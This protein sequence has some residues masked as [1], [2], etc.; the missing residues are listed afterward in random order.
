M[1]K[2]YGG[3]W[4]ITG[5]PALGRGG[6]SEVF[7]VTDESGAL[8]GEYALKR[9][10]NPVRHERFRAEIEA[11]R[12][13]S[14]PNIIRLIDHSALEVSEADVERQYLVMPIAL[15]G[16]LADAGRVALYKDNIE[17]TLQVAL[18][19]ASALEAAHAADIIHRD[20]KPANVLFTGN[21][22][23]VWLTDFGICLIREAE[24]NT[25]LHEVV[26]PRSFM[27]PELEAGGRLEVTPAADI[28][29]LGKLI[30]F[31]ISGGTILP[32]EELTDPRFAHLFDRGERYRRVQLLLTRMVCLLDRRLTTMADVV[33][34]LKAI[35]AWES[36]AIS[37]PLDAAAR[38]GISRL[39]G[40][41]LR[42]QQ[43]AVEA[44][45]A[46]ASRDQLIA[47]VRQA[48]ST[49]AEVEFKKLAAHIATPQIA[50]SVLPLRLAPNE[51]AVAQLGARS[52]Y[53]LIAGCE[54]VLE[55]SDPASSHALQ[56]L[57]CI[58]R[59]FIVQVS[60]GNVPPP[61]PE[62]VIPEL[63]VLS[64]YARH[65][66][67]GGPGAPPR[68]VGFMTQRQSVGKV[69]RYAEVLRPGTAPVAR[70]VTLA[71][72]AS[73]FR[74]E[75]SLNTPFKADEWNLV[76]EKVRAQLEEA[77]GVFIDF[78]MEQRP[79]IGA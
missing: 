13:L 73:A 42:N 37:L 69:V 65:P 70:S 68:R 78:V 31:M 7:P 34:Q 59:T 44:A 36:S 21:G 32:R 10:L 26:G 76:L 33:A 74:P 46:R 22:H 40:L 67:A 61:V 52:H 49:W 66:S 14:H 17:G 25:E 12:R 24:R 35:E 47:S 9:V 60:R 6:Q 4:R 53:E 56:L 19:L 62:V 54:L 39:Q 71:R 23:E 57:L 79:S 8:D 38:D 48:F 30:Y 29:S 16:S 5:G 77:L 3:R 27:A 72:V 45:A 15:G 41:A 1:T 64:V 50:V 2:P 58:K 28:Y 55:I 43:A 75:N 63:A 20:V 18:Q 51:P 11:I